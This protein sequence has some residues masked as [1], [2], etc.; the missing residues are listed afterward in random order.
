MTLG[1]PSGEAFT[2]RLFLGVALTVLIAGIG[3]YALIAQRVRAEV[4]SSAERELSARVSAFEAQAPQRGNGRAAV[5]RLAS[6]LRGIGH[7]RQVVV[8]DSR[9]RMV[10]GPPSLRLLA[11]SLASG[12]SAQLVHPPGGTPVVR[13]RSSVHSGTGLYSVSAERD[14]GDYSSFLTEV[15]ESLT[16]LALP[17]IGLSLALFWLL[18]GRSLHA[19]HRG[20]LERAARDGLTG[21]GNHRAF[22]EELRKA[23][24]LADRS[25][26]FRFA[27][28]VFDVNDFKFLNDRRGHQHGDDVLRRIGDVLTR[29]R[30]Q[31]RPF[32]TGGDEFALIL[33]A[34]TEHEAYVAL[35]RLRKQIA[36]SA[37]VNV[38]VGISATRGDMRAA[39]LIREEAEAALAEAKRLRAAGPVKF[40][41]VSGQAVI[42]TPEKVHAVRLLLSERALDVALQ[43]IWNLETGQVLGLEAL[44]RPHSDYGL[45]GPA[46]A[47]DI[48]E[49][50]GRIADLDRLCISRILECVPR[51]PAPTRVFVNIHPASL[52]ID[53]ADGDWLYDAVRAAGIA[54][55]RIVVEVTERS[56]ARVANLV[57]SVAR[58]RQQGFLVA[59]DDV[60]A[61][62]SGLE[63]LHLVS[64]DFVKVDRAIVARAV[65]D[66]SARAALVAVAA[67]AHETGTFVIA[68]GIEDAEALEFLRTLEIRAPAGIRGGQ[69]Y[70]LGRPAPTVEQAMAGGPLEAAPAAVPENVVPFQASVAA[71]GG[72]RST[73]TAPR[74][75]IV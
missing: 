1:R 61:G 44:A 50:I 58:L 26:N 49:Q 29:G 62:N 17:A 35:S 55:E 32:R 11:S 47:F 69:G 70:G 52:D 2:F 30:S 59:L 51:V 4:V 75:P 15:R 22:Q 74:A 9:G 65:S 27:L 7:F 54:P 56:G 67:F 64:V 24:S 18:A 45:N 21:L 39:A 43:P 38:A 12:P 63:M 40:S 57:R 28:A 41:A 8:V 6:Q 42:L 48:A 60:G 16:M 13:L 5:R 33:P 10:S 31:D 46:E 53:G 20:A 19:R 68:E 73:Y 66:R 14:A 34:T 25:P 72:A 71:G 36:D 23:A 37:G 3:G